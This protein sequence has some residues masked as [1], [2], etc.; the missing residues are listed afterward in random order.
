MGE[1]GVD[2]VVRPHL[3][4]GRLDDAQR[5][6]ASVQD[7]GLQP[8]FGQRFPFASYSQSAEQVAVLV[9]AAINAPNSSAI[10]G[11]SPQP[12]AEYPSSRTGEPAGSVPR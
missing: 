4:L 6:A 5:I 9:P 7:D 8:G 11:E 3:Y 1:P 2:L 10:W 12:S